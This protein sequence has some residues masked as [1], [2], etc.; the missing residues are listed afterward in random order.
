MKTLYVTDLDGTLLDKNS[1]VTETAK[2][3]LQA[4]YERGVM[5][6]PATSRSWSAL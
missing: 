6:S 3:A 4:L 2:R 5:V 1:R